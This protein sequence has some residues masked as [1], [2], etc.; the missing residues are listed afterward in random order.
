MAKTHGLSSALYVGSKDLSGDVGA[1]N[2]IS[3]SQATLDKTGINKAAMER[4]VG[5]RD[6][7]I[8]FTSYFNPATSQAHPTLSALPTTDVLVSYFNHTTKGDPAASCM[9]KQVGY[10]PTR[11]A[12]GSLTLNTSAVAN[13][14]G[15]EWGVQLTAGVQTDTAATNSTGL[16]QTA[17]TTNGAQAYLHVFSFSGTS[18]TV[19]IEDSADNVTYANLLSFT[20]ATGGTFERKTVAGTVDR[21]VRIATTG[22]FSSCAFAV[23]FVRNKRAV[24]F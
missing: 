20:A 1:V 16:D 15:L 11:G 6:G 8:E 2:R 7:A 14:Y 17:Q 4:F 5:L 10:D 24:N 19:S 12:D 22:T 23:V 13:A 21:Y 18:C 9:A 3:T